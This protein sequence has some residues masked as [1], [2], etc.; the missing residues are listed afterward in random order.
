[1]LK[2]YIGLKFPGTCDQAFNFYKSVFKVEFNMFIRMRDDPE[3]AVGTPPIDLDKVAYAEMTIG[4][5]V[6]T[7]DDAME[8]MGQKVTPGDM[9]IIIVEPDSKKEVDRLFTALAA[10]G[11]IT[12]KPT[13][14][15][16]GYLGGLI[17][18]FGI[19]WAVWFRPAPVK[20][21]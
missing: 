11:K 13:E 10:G 6:I 20:Q 2:T 14:Y 15:P 17:D 5:L 8:S 7:G 1:M 4:G 9:A 16:W 3:T 12:T 21:A 19:C 18:K